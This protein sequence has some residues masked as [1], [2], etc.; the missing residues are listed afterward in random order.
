MKQRTVEVLDIERFDRYWIGKK[1]RTKDAF[2][3]YISNPI[4]C[5]DAAHKFNLSYLT[6][7]QHSSRLRKKGIIKVTRLYRSKEKLLENE[8]QHLR[9]IIRK[10]LKSTSLETLKTIIK[11]QSSKESETE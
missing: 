7:Q 11:L 1:P 3:Y 4:T 2:T 8:K 6:L 5:F 9:G 10:N